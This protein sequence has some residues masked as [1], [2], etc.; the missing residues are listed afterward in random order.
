MV[1]KVPHHASS[2]SNAELFFTEEVARS[3]KNRVAIVAPNAPRLPES[4]VKRQY[5]D[6]GYRVFQTNDSIAVVDGDG[7]SEILGDE[8]GAAASGV[9]RVRLSYEGSIEV[10]TFGNATR[11]NAAVEA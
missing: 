1:L 11:I 9:V 7:L 8:D 5:L 6:A 3:F 10:D 4:E 2:T